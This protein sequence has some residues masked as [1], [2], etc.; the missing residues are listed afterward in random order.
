MHQFV[1]DAAGALA[2]LAFEG[3]DDELEEGFLE[4]EL[5]DHACKFVM[6]CIVLYVLYCFEW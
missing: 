2:D 1:G 6:Y 3:Q 4:S 5:P